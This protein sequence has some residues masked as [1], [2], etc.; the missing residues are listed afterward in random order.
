MTQELQELNGYHRCDAPAW[1]VVEKRKGRM[2]SMTDT[3]Y[4]QLVEAAGGAAGVNSYIR[5]Q[6]GL[7]PRTEAECNKLY[8]A[9]RDATRRKC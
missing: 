3:E 5:E 4:A 2:I 6:L 1:P 9:D 8:C 7:L